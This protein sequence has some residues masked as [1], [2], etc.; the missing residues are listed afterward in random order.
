M[1]YLKLFWA[2]F[3]IGLFSI[4][5]GYAALPLIQAQV[6]QT[7]A[8]LDMRE[9]TD[10]VTISQMT[11]GPIAI[12]A[13][14]FVGTRIAGLTGSLVATFGCVLPSFAIV[15]F[16]AWLYKRY[17]NLR[18]VQSVLCSLQPAVV[19]LIASAG[20]TM[21]AH[22]LWNCDLSG[23]RLSSTDW[24]SAAIMVA[25]IAVLRK[26]KVNPILVMLGAGVLGGLIFTFL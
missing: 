9:F 19:G 20:V 15:L 7:Y 11:P 22:A 8:W 23:I 17:K 12:N 10:I 18:Y 4:G 24:V 1:L 13:A 5:G 26:W 6:V 25:G 14:S 16:F 2:F 3:Q 21:I